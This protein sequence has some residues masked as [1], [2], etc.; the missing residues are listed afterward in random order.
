MPAKIQKQSVLKYNDGCEEIQWLT[1][2]Y[3]NKALNENGYAS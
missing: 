1:G 3:L 2:L